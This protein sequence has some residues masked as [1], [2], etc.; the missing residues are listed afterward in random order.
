MKKSFL[1]AALAGLAASTGMGISFVDGS[2]SV[3]AA[4]G[5][6]AQGQ[7]LPP[8]KTVKGESP[9]FLRYGGMMR[10]RP[11]SYPRPGWSV[12]QGKRMARKSRNRSR[13]RSAHRA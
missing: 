4:Q 7:Q 10:F 9:A 13:N 12:A 3:S 2:T 8:G 5:S 6:S 1:L 11:A